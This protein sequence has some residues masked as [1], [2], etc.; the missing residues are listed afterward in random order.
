M[1]TKRQKIVNGKHKMGDKKSER[2]AR[3]RKK[4]E[5]EAEKHNAL[6]KA[7]G[8]ATAKQLLRTWG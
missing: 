6:V 5:N 2:I 1:E 8:G 4:I 7:F 3:L